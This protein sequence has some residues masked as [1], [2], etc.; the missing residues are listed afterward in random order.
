MCLSHCE[1]LLWPVVGVPVAGVDGCG[2]G[3][4]HRGRI[5]AHKSFNFKHYLRSL[6]SLTYPLH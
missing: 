2:G 1:G 3:R 4:G 6:Y 5:G